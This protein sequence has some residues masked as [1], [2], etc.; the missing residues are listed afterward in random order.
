MQPQNSVASGSR[1]IQTMENFL[2]IMNSHF[3][4]WLS[5]GSTLFDIDPD[6]IFLSAAGMLLLYLWYLILS[7][8]LPLLRKNQDIPKVRKY[9]ELPRE[10]LYCY[11]PFCSEVR[12]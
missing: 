6:S 2:S 7:P 5:S 1:A 4:S 8:I 10:S 11:V 9:G 12:E 3:E